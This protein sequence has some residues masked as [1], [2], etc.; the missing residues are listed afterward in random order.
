[1]SAEREI[2][3]EYLEQYIQENKAKETPAATEERPE[4]FTEQSRPLVGQFAGRLLHLETPLTEQEISQARTVGA[5]SLEVDNRAK[6][7]IKDELTPILRGAK[8]FRPK[9]ISA[10][11]AAAAERDFTEIDDEN[12]DD[13]SL[14]GGV[15][16]VAERARLAAFSKALEAAPETALEGWDMTGAQRDIIKQFL[17]V[18]FK[19]NTEYLRHNVRTRERLPYTDADID[20]LRERRF[21]ANGL[22]EIRNN[23]LQT[24]EQN[25]EPIFG[26]AERDNLFLRYLDSLRSLYE[27]FTEDGQT[28]LPHNERLQRS[29]KAQ[30]IFCQ[31]HAQ[32]PNFP[33][34]V[35]PA[36][37]HYE[38]DEAAAAKKKGDW[39]KFGFDPEI[40]L[41]WQN[42]ELGGKQV[43][44]GPLRDKFADEM[45]SRFSALATSDDVRR[46]QVISAE[47]IAVSGI[48]ISEATTGQE[49]RNIVLMVASEDD[50]ESE[51]EIN[52]K[53][54]FADPADAELVE[55]EK[56]AELTRELT[57]LHEFGHGLYPEISKA[58]D[59]LGEY[60]DL[61]AE[62][63]SELAASVAAPQVLGAKAQEWFGGKA[64]KAIQLVML[65]EAVKYLEWYDDEAYKI[66]GQEIIGA[67]GTAG[68]INKK[69]RK[70]TVSAND[71]G[72]EL[73]DILTA[74]LKETLKIYQTAGRG[75]PS[76]IRTARRQAGTFLKALKR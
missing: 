20:Q 57:L 3:Q 71:A 58:A 32:F 40:R 52:E 21:T 37:S 1:M 63:K 4:V 75:T 25:K 67:L 13:V 30:E 39:K 64:T 12:E 10:L 69:G 5:L 66:T 56:F 22:E 23:I 8:L 49:E 31:L 17:G 38:S 42:K 26:S 65:R 14:A 33:L 19:I 47:P 6:Q 27:P 11:V 2:P 74:K 76:A 28:P 60:D 15:A 51:A 62:L 46:Y 43:V 7:A 61:L 24:V 68:L 41:Y 50:K 53:L 55:S 72:P 18:I 34:V 45:D 70:F 35:F 73:M 54:E 29:E 59:N 44:Y 9:Q 36:F 48:N 16:L